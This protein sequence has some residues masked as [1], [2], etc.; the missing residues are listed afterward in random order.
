MARLTVISGLNRKSAAV[1]LVESDGQR[2]LLDCGDGL[3][4]GEHPDLAGLGRI[5]AVLLSHAHIDHA[6]SLLRLGEIGNPPVFATQRTFG[7]LPEAFRPARMIEIPEAGTFRLGDLHLATG[8]CGHA[9][10]GVWFHLP[11]ESGGFVYSGDIS[12][13]SPGMPFDM[14]PPAATL[15]IDASYG[16]RDT[17]LSEQIDDI[18]AAARSG[19]VLCCPAAGRGADMALAMERC[20]LDVVLDAVVADEF[21][22]ATGRNLPSTDA[23][24]A[25]PDQVII[26]TASNAESG[27][28]G[29]LLAR[30]GF[31]FIFSSH[32]PKASP[33]FA[34]IADKAARWMA[35]NVHPRRRDILKLA[36]HCGAK[37]VLPAFVDMREAPV[38]SAALGPR[39]KLERETEI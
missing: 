6:G 1:F 5:D 33:A 9:P 20:G 38:L 36:D 2:I 14:P 19:A 13:E 34:L 15:L 39:L 16:D 8:A 26:A 27:L 3:E 29:Q 22:A 30:G 18:A 37:T 21:L 31:H 23:K 17:S 24:R 7:F 12:L 32:V 11:T 28:S 10:G 4:P 25:R 35:W